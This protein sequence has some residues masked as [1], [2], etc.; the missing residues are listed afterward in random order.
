MLDLLGSIFETAQESSFTLLEFL[1]CSAA[2]LLLGALTAAAFT[3]QTRHSKGFALTLAI[4]PLAVQV[5]IML[6]NGNLGAGVAVAG[7]FSL[8]R[9][10]SAQGSAKEICA[11]FITMAVGLACGMGYL[12]VAALLV[13]I[14]G[15]AALV[16]E[17]VR[18]GEAK[19]A[20]R[21]LRITVP[22]GMDYI[23]AF[24]KAFAAY[25]DQSELVQVKTAGMGSLFKLKYNIVP[26]KDM[27]EKN[28]IDA[29]RC[30]NG[31]LEISIG[32]PMPKEDF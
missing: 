28:L 10:R 16:L 8:V 3:H 15:A 25:I 27:N 26:K 21:E 14:A 6:V 19:Q 31:N 11:I 17:R 22:E 13:V 9:F 18:F 30:L 29:L 5:V 2:S 4:L 1:S 12:A 23:G 24:D 20:V 7:A 32:L